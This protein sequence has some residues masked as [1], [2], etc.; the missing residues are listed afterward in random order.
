MPQLQSGGATSGQAAEQE[1]PERIQELTQLGWLPSSVAGS[2]VEAGDVELEA[3]HTLESRGVL[4]ASGLARLHIGLQLR[5]VRHSS[6]AGIDR[7]P[8]P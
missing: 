4:T 8:V 2:P 7:L 6:A 5:T 1:S 3:L